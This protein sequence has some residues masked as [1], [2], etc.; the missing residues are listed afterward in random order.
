MEL[1]LNYT[2]DKAQFHPKKRH[3]AKPCM[4]IGES[5]GQKK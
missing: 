4:P 3:I 5:K 2:V 1:G